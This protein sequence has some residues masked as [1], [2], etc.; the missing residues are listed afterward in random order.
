MSTTQK[1]LIIAEVGVNH[2]GDLQ[3]AKRLV[4]AAT[5]AGADVVKFQT[6]QATQLATEHATQAAYQQKC[7]DNAESQLKMLQRLEL[8]PAD[9]LQLIDYCDQKQIEFLSTAFDLISIDLLASFKIKR[10]K[11]PSGEITNLP[12]LREIGRQGKPV[13]LS[14]GMADLSEI[15]SAIEA[16]EHVGLLRTQ[17]TVLHCTTE[18]PAPLEEVNLRAMNS[19]AHAFGV[20]VGY[21]DHTDGIAV[22][23]AAV[24]LGAIVIEKHLTL[25]R[26]MHGPDHKASLE[27]D[28]FASMVRG[29]RTVELAFGDG[30]KRPTPCEIPNKAVARKSLVASRPIKKGE[31]FTEEN[32]TS[33][34]PGS[35]ISPMHWD[36]LIGRISS[37]QYLPD[38]LIEW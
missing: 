13:I 38:D 24:A 37:R 29:I 22:P 33:K 32:I 14:T 35:G 11:I 20:K 23:I 9:H 36:L 5:D 15:E 28:Q 21:S 7:L 19:I 8:S 10:W 31:A 34:R 30:I 16:L 27:P 2:N 17:I 3:L 12:Y 18:Y 25:D 4:D 6:F 26:N 1:T